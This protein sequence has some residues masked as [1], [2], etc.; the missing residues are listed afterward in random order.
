[1]EAIMTRIARHVMMDENAVAQGK[2]FN[3]FTN[4]HNFTG[5]LMTK[6]ARGH[7]VFSIDLLQVRTT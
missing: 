5:R 2:T 6:P 1:M 7:G 4:C 3:T